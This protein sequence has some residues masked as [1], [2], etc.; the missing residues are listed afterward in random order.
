MWQNLSKD[1]SRHKAEDSQD[2]EIIEETSE[3]QQPS[4]NVATYDHDPQLPG[5]PSRTQASLA[6]VLND[7][8][9][10]GK[11]AKEEVEHIEA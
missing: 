10:M 2:E 5:N 1:G 9:S 6:R 7:A 4:E 3:Q 8:R 11:E